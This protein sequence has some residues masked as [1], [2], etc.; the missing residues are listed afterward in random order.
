MVTDSR[1]RRLL[2][3]EDS[4]KSAVAIR[5]VLRGTCTLVFAKSIA[6][7][8]AHL[9]APGEWIGWIVDIGLPDGSGLDLVEHWQRKRP[10]VPVLFFTASNDKRDLNRICALRSLVLTKPVSPRKIV[11]FVA[12][13]LNQDA[14]FAPRVSAAY[15]MLV[16]TREIT[17]AEAAVLGLAIRGLRHEEIEKERGISENT[18]KAQIGGLMERLD[19]GSLEDCVIVVYRYA[20]DPD[21]T[22]LGHE[23]RAAVK[24]RK[25][26]GGTTHRRKR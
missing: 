20:V 12:H 19:A 21:A 25:R 3:V 9:T 18:L 26:V 7:A 4:E 1:K 10:A 15:E 6:E 13:C 16:Q 5:Y 17:S 11:P 22:D 24:T 23:K 14:N 2:I 8:E